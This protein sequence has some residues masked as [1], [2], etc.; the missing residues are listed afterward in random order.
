GPIE[1]KNTQGLLK[2]LLE[3]D[4]GYN[5]AL[6]ELTR[7]AEEAAGKPEIVERASEK[8]MREIERLIE[9]IMQGDARTVTVVIEEAP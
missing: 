8:S 6:A 9:L 7:A 3:P 2:R 4:D 1:V 5:L